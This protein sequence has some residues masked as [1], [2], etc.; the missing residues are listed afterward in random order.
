ML[1]SYLCHHSA[2]QLRA[3]AADLLSHVVSTGAAEVLPRA[4]S[5]MTDSVYDISG[6]SA[7]VRRREALQHVAPL[8]SRWLEAPRVA[9]MLAPCVHKMQALAVLLLAEPCP[10]LRGEA[11]QLLLILSPV[12]AAAA[13]E[14]AGGEGGALAVDR[15]DRADRASASSSGHPHPQHHSHR[16]QHQGNRSSVALSGNRLLGTSAADAT[17][18]GGGAGGGSSVCSGAGPAASGTSSPSS[19]GAGVAAPAA[20]A[21]SVAQALLVA[22]PSVAE[23]ALSDPLG[24]DLWGGSVGATP[25]VSRA[26]VRLRENAEKGCLRG[27][28]ESAGSS[29]AEWELWLSC[30]HGCAHALAASGAPCHATLRELWRLIFR[31]GD[32]TEDEKE[33]GYRGTPPRYPKISTSAA[34]PLMWAPYASL[35]CACSPVILADDDTI[36]HG[37]RDVEKMLRDAVRLLISSENEGYRMAAAAVLGQLRGTHAVQLVLAELGQWLNLSGDR[38][39][40]W[41]GNAI[42]N[43]NSKLHVQMRQLAHVFALLSCQ[44]G[45]TE[46]VTTCRADLR[47]LA[48][49]M[50]GALDY[51]HLQYNIHAWSLQRARMYTFDLLA[52][53]T[54]A[55]LSALEKAAQGG[56][57]LRDRAGLRPAAV[58]ASVAKLIEDGASEGA[59][60]AA[61]AE[62]ARLLAEIKKAGKEAD[63]SLVEAKVKE[64]TTVQ[65]EAVQVAALRALTALATPEACGEVQPTPEYQPLRCA[66]AMI[67]HP[68]ER[69]SQAARGAICALWAA[70]YDPIPACLERSYASIGAGSGGG[71]GGA[72]GA[73]TANAHFVALVTVALRPMERVA[74]PGSAAG[75]GGDHSRARSSWGL[76][77][78]Q[79]RQSAEDRSIEARRAGSSRSLANGD[80]ANNSAN[81][82]ANNATA[83]GSGSF[84][85]SGAAFTAAVDREEYCVPLI[86]LALCKLSD[87]CPQVRGA[88]AALLH[89]QGG[90][91]NAAAPPTLI[92]EGLPWNAEHAQLALSSR[93]PRHARARPR[94]RARGASSRGRGASRARAH[95]RLLSAAVARAA[96]LALLPPPQLIATSSSPTLV[97]S[98]TTT[99]SSSRR[100]LSS[101]PPAPRCCCYTRRRPHRPRGRACSFDL[102]SMRKF[103]TRAVP[104]PA[105][106]PPSP[107]PS[108]RCGAPSRCAPRACRRS[109]AS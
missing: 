30:L 107:R 5:A 29:D 32:P 44:S 96:S 67:S 88:A 2:P 1:A 45:W 8:I 21:M 81:N 37:R 74:A 105:S 25:A 10:K 58:L 55:L 64:E 39:Y 17:A 79:H 48:S 20:P 61:D 108:T 78:G 104:R 38:D 31:G 40:E 41:H 13:A 59:A 23:H 84:R 60:Q 22:L 24:L 69:V 70:C 33:R 9:R 15:A 97:A 99:S 35:A 65:A 19:G 4:L 93:S 100:R 91:S 66:E 34:L 11:A 109:S 53:T 12:A 80:A 92:A 36:G 52:N 6:A 98:T 47:A 106:R 76:T 86:V 102:S 87:P 89:S 71:N 14:S 77:P 72:S 73:A 101:R 56:G 51:L 94:G 62:R 28:V 95:H 103:Y 46:V 27:F 43:P 75:G 18:G 16:L 85:A 57:S 26:G 68:S 50:H 7:R 42:K 63:H 49:W 3:A 82:S 83:G 90:S 54:P